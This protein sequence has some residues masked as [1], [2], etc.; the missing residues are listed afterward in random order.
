MEQTDVISLPD[1]IIIKIFYFLEDDKRTQ[2]NL[3]IMNK[4]YNSL[5]KQ[6]P[7]I[8][9][10]INKYVNYLISKGIE[11][12]D[13]D[14]KVSEIYYNFSD[15]EYEVEWHIENM[16][17]KFHQKKNIEIDQYS[18]GILN[19]NIES[20]HISGIITDKIPESLITNLSLD[21]NKFMDKQIAD[22]HPNSNYKI[23]DII[24][25]SLYPYIF[26][27]DGVKNIDIDFWGCN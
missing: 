4:H 14:K 13:Y 18:N 22:F 6:K 8:C 26:K 12:D 7:F 10:V 16:M 27:K 19:S 15:D 23:R 25:P 3:K 17:N 11:Y 9:E 1:D 5:L 20:F 2:Y 24:H 21:I